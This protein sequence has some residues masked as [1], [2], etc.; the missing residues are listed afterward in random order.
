MPETKPGWI[1]PAALVVAVVS[2][3][4]AVWALVRSPSSDDSKLTADEAKAQVCQAF[5]MVRKAVSLQTNANLGPDRIAIEAVAANARLATLGGG[6]FLLARLDEGPV[7]ADLDDAVRSF[8]NQLE[9]IGMGQLAGAAG[10][11]PG[12]TTRMTEAQVSAERALE[13]CK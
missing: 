8:A 10:D 7:P 6:Q 5:D 11:D 3:A 13:L 9:Y 12:Q 2:V 1:A 4:L